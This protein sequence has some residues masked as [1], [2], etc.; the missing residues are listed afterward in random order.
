[1]LVCWKGSCVDGQMR[2]GDELISGAPDA[3]FIYL[4]VATG[5]TMEYEIGDESELFIGSMPG[6]SRPYGSVPVQRR[7]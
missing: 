1:M 7:A 4:V 6:V 2:A 3:V 5:V